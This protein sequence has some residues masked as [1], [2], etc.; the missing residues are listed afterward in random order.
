MTT[1]KQQLTIIGGGLAGCE[2][3][4]QA[5]QRG[6][7]VVLYE[8]RPTVPTAV[9]RTGDLAELVCSNSLKSNDLDK[10]SG[11]LKAE[12][13]RLDSLI[14]RCADAS[15]VPAGSALA[16]DRVQF[17]QLITQRLEEHPCVTV[18]REEMSTIPDTPCIV[19]SG[20]LTA[21]RL[22]HSIQEILGGQFLNFF[23]AVSPIVDA[24]TLDYDKLFHASRYDKGEA[25]YWNV[26]LDEAQYDALH[27]AL[28]TAEKSES[29][30]DEDVPYFESCLPIEEM[31]ERGR[32]TMR[33]GPLRGAGLTDPHTGRWP[34]AC[35]QLRPENV[36]AT[37][38]NLV[39]FQTRLKWPEQTRV[40]R[41]LPGLENVEIVRFGVIHKNIFINSPAVLRPTFQTQRR[42][43]LFFAGQLTGVE[44]YVESAAAG[45]MAG[46]NAARLLQNKAPVAFPRETILGSLAHYITSADHKHFQPMNSNWAL[47]PPL[48][49]KVK[50][51]E[52]PARHAARALAALQEF[53]DVQL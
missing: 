17:T 18:R 31:A 36:E 2:A 11:L 19:A 50:K 48:P 7:E 12:M 26:P 40:L 16:V 9:H 53:M 20:P 44:G 4:W 35:V 25:A 42:A 6:T 49:E 32:L 29:H 43:D 47:L 13:R 8:M 22:A 52:K 39:G 10:A 27:Q 38:Y 21:E 5:A 34:F 24:D 45:L 23:D 3:A 1:S 33:Y 15:A 28:L 46:V 51:A 41:L 14:I 30:N 37:M